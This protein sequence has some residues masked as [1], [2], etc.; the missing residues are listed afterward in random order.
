MELNGARSNPRPQLELARLGEIHEELLRKAALA[1][2]KPRSASPTRQPVLATVT[3]VLDQSDW[4][5]RTREIHAAAEHLAGEPLRWTSVKGILSANASGSDPRF[6]RVRPGYYEIAKAMA[7]L[8]HR[9]G[10]Q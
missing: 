8:E 1:P 6:R 3:R 10:Q 2:R 7:H 4:P 5:M 9:A